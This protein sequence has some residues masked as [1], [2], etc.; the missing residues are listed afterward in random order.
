MRSSRWLLLIALVVG[1]GCLNVAQRT[2]LFLTGY[3]VGQRA[4]R[5]HAQEADVLWLKMQVVGLS[6]PAHLAEVA[7]E[8]RLKLVAWSTLK[9]EP[10]VP[11]SPVR[12]ASAQDDASD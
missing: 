11:A 8:R 4:Q 7:Q 2:A 9:A 5:A 12:V 1:V 3:G 10:T 6:S